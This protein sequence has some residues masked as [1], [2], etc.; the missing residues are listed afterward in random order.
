ML[1][2]I[3]VSGNVSYCLPLREY[4]VFVSL[5]SHIYLL[6]SVELDL[7]LFLKEAVWLLNLDLNV[8]IYNI[9]LKYTKKQTGNI[10][11]NKKRKPEH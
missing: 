2:C 6:S 11:P 7:F 1:R 9:Y 5:R 3:S 8:Y 4:S 10:E